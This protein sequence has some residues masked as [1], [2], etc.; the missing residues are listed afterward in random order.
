MP[1]ETSYPSCREID[2]TRDGG[3]GKGPLRGILSLG[4]PLETCSE[5][6]RLF[7]GILSPRQP[8]YLKTFMCPLFKRA[9]IGALKLRSLSALHKR[10]GHLASDQGHLRYPLAAM[11]ES[12]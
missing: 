1:G 2:D 4:G 8:P 5:R 9:S 7:G 12:I 6:T 10:A 11:H 3:I